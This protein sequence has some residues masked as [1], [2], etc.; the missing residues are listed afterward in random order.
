MKSH[1]TPPLSLSRLQNVAHAECWFND[2]GDP[3]TKGKSNEDRES[4]IMFTRV[5]F[6]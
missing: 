3:S 1:S 5:S 2:L 6:N 4:K